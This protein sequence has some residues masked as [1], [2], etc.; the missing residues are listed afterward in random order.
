MKTKIF[1][2][3]LIIVLYIPLT[4]QQHYYIEAS[5]NAIVRENPDIN[6]SS[7]LTLKKGD[8]LNA[9]TETQTNDFY[10]VFL[11]NGE[12]GWVSRYVVRL[13]TGQAPE[14]PPLAPL[15][16]VGGGLT[17]AEKEYAAFHLAIGQ[18]KGFKEIIRKGFVIGY[19][20]TRKIPLW[21]QYRLT[22][23]RSENNTYPRPA[24][25]YEDSEIHATGRASLDDYSVVSPNYV[26]GHLAPAEDMRWDEQA[27]A[28]CMLLSN[29][30]PQ[31]GDGFNN[32][33]W[34]TLE[35]H[36]RGWAVDRKDIIVICGPVFEVRPAVFNIPRQ[37]TTTN[38]M[39]YN[40]AG[41][42]NV[43]IATEFFKIIVDMR[44][45]NNP[46]VLAFLMPNIP[47]KEG[48]ERKIEKYLTS[49]DKIERLTGLD[50]LTA[51]PDQVQG[52][53]E[54]KVAQNIW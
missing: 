45:P 1:F 18:P 3:T 25:F 21:V 40:V 6:S 24:N 46:N 17:S 54:S 38:Q 35:N 31:V 37:H 5:R 30:A 29:I 42:N 44:N 26:K 23:V 7:K 20:P 10:H 19:D 14:A 53:I 33:I 9:V 4:A 47:T 51:L 13:Y 41:D 27:E 15:P 2:I 22:K 28:D 52:N 36:V 49:V 34:K 48:D 50:F 8:Q 32:S 43:A 39:L 11:P 12:T 16:N